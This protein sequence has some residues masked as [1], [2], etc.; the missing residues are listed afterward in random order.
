VDLVLSSPNL[1]LHV[2]LLFDIP[3]PVQP[4][5]TIAAV[6]L[7]DPHALSLTQILV[8]GVLVSATVLVLGATGLIVVC[9]PL[10]SSLFPT[11]YHRRSPLTPWVISP[12]SPPP[13]LF[14]VAD[15]LVP[16]PVVRGVQMGTGLGLASKGFLM[17]FYDDHEPQHLRPLLGVDSLMVAI[18]AAA[19][20]LLSL[21]RTVLRHESSCDPPTA[22][23]PFPAAL[24]LVLVGVV[25]A[26]CRDPAA[27]HELRLGPAVP[28]VPR[29]RSSDWLP[30][31]TRAALPQ[32]PL[33]VLNSVVAVCALSEELFPQRVRA[34]TRSL[35]SASLS[36][37]RCA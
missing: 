4:M 23:A 16:R 33:T 28:E 10:I 6:S 3:M 22:A 7:A 15:T 36:T 35:A 14:Q 27:A 31:L 11:A 32:L 20:L 25:M 19:F 30:A 37:G 8:A 5:K 12:P 2:G 18:A 24:V 21:R 34:S 26:L 17:A 9:E 13:P 1:R 29:I